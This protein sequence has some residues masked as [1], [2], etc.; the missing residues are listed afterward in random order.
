LSSITRHNFRQY[1]RRFDASGH[2]FVQHL[3]LNGT[4][5]ERGSRRGSPRCDW[6]PQHGGKQKVTRASLPNG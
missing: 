1:R 6:Q 3:S 4:R 2:K 5:S